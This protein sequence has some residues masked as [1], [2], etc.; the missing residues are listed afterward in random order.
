MYYGG[1]RTSQMLAGLVLQFSALHFWFSKTGEKNQKKVKNCFS[2]P[3]LEL[4]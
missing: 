4:P 3:A 1:S 2:I